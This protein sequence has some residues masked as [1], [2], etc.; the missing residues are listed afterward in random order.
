MKLASGT[1][2]LNLLFFGA[3]GAGKGTYAARLTKAWEIPH[4]STGDM[5]R[6]EIK[7]GSELGRKF[8][9]YSN[10][11]ALVPDEVVVE[12]VQKRLNRPDC[13]N[14]WILDGFPRTV[15]QGKQLQHFA[16]PALCVNIYLPDRLLIQ[17]LTG[18]RVCSDCGLNYNMADIREGEFEMP[19]LVP[20]R[21]DCDKC[22]GNPNLIQ[23]EDDKEEVVRR[24]LQIYKDQS[25]PLLKFYESS[26]VLLNFPVKKGVRD[27]PELMR[28]LAVK[29]KKEVA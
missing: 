17:K 7:E 11:G 15:P 12:M 22:Q 13:A 19:P 28:Q 26:S 25:E 27:F 18:R 6:A 14:G 2:P 3:P 10:S 4:I 9:E 23:R 29:L 8:R 21:E 16:P 5:I 1:G 20:K 24:R